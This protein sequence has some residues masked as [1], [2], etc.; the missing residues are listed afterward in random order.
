MMLKCTTEFE[1]WDADTSFEHVEG[2]FKTS[3]EVALWVK[4]AIAQ[5]T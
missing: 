1:L 2:S 3:P 4:K 5:R